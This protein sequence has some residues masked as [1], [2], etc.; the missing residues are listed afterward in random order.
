M[1]MRGPDSPASDFK[2]ISATV[3]TAFAAGFPAMVTRPPIEAVRGRTSRWGACALD[4]AAAIRSDID[5]IEK[6]L[7]RLRF[8]GRLRCI[9]SANCQAKVST[10]VFAPEAQRKLAGGGA[11]A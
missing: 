4:C 8:M 5:E 10:Q 1:G 3:I 11:R 9:L 2:S 6:R 7:S